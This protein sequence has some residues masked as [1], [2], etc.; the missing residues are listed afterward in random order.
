MTTIAISDLRTNLPS[1]IDQV[2]E[3]LIRFVITVSG[4]PKAVVI[5]L[6][7]LESLEETAEVLSSSGV[8]KSIKDSQK[9]VRNGE[10]INLKDLE[11]KYRLK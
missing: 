11:E 7:E 1:L 8:L 5:S 3:S 6:D 4:K 10:F 9:K 2:S